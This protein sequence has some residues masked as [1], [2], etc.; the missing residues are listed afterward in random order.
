MQYEV[1]RSAGM[2]DEW[3]VEATDYERD[4]VVYLTLFLG[5]D[6]EAR[7]REY[8]EFKNSGGSEVMG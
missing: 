3:R 5:P 4:G 1:A 7:A 8:A 2:Q 6:A